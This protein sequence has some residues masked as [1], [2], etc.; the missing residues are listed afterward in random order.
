[1]QNII[2]LPDTDIALLAMCGNSTAISRPYGIRWSGLSMQPLYSVQIIKKTSYL[3][4]RAM[5]L[6]SFIFRDK[7]LQVAG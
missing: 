1:M 7:A 2:L 5:K 3:Q 4:Y 6:A